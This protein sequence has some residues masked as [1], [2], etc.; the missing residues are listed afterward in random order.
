ME[1]FSHVRKHPKT[2]KLWE[3][4]SVKV[5]RDFETVH[6]IGGLKEYM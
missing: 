5:R 2:K 4:L 3:T 1:I 6:D